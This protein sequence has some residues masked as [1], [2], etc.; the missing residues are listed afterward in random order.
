MTDKQLNLDAELERRLVEWAEWFLQGCGY[1]VGYPGISS[2]FWACYQIAKTRGRGNSQPLP[3][4]PSAEEVDEWVR[5]L[6]KWLPRVAEVIRCHYFT[7][8]PIRDKSER[9]ALS[10]TQYLRDLEKGKA[11]LCCALT[12]SKNRK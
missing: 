10:H 9:I 2:T 1:K 7:L 8:G 12:A 3:S 4:F 6:T 5:D 11:W